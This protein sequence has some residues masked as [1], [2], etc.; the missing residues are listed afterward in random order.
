[1]KLLISLCLSYSE[2]KPS[3][4]GERVLGFGAVDMDYKL[5]LGFKRPIYM[6]YIF[7]L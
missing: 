1:V 5:Y 4:E 3:Q 6:N 7:G 2:L